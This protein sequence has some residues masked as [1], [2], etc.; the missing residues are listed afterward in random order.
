LLASSLAGRE[1]T[2]L[3]LVRKIVWANPVHPYNA[4][5]RLA[6]IDARGLEEA[7]RNHGLESAL[8]LLRKAGVYLTHDE[9]KGKREIVRSG[10]HIASNAMSFGNPAMQGLIETSSGGSRSPGTLTRQI[11]KHNVSRDPYFALSYQEFNLEGS[12]EIHVRDILPVFD[13]LGSFLRVSRM[14]HRADHWFSVSGGLGHF[15]HYRAVTNAMVAIANLSGA[16]VPFPRILPPNDFTPVARRIAELRRRGVRCLVGTS[17][18]RA[19][20]IAAAAAETGSDI[21]GTV[22][23]AGGESMTEAKRAAIEATGAE[24]TVVYWIHEIGPVGM[25]CRQLRGNC[26]HHF[27]DN[28]AVIA[29]GRIAPL[30]QTPLSSLLFTTLSITAPRFLINV[31][32][33]DAGTMQ[34]ADCGCCFFKT[35]FTSTIRNIFS[36]GKLTGQG[37]TLVGTDLVRILEERLPV[38]LGGRPGDYQLVEQEGPAQTELVLRVSPRTG[39]TSAEAVRSRFLDELRSF[40]G[41]GPASRV[42]QH[43]DGVRVLFQEP[44]MTSRG[45]VL[46]LHLLGTM[47]SGEKI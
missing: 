31:E 3:D 30:S 10:R 25:S 8:E 9:F 24:V 36:F 40:N 41:G 5:F 23:F 47:P 43:A 29:Y 22:F 12:A 38:T 27:S 45:K 35:G 4:M 14:G 34:P 13:G 11:P 37:V 28:S 16:R 26:V 6:G 46:P 44:V 19:V 20:R 32:M 39:L 7:V 1:D 15:G 17:A 21:S 2:F 33:D 42:F 18:S